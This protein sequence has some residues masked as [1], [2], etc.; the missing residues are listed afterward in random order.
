MYLRAYFFRMAGI[1]AAKAEEM[2]A[3]FLDAAT[4]VAANQQWTYQGRIYTRANLAEIQSS[5]EFWDTQCKRLARGGIRV[6]GVMP[7]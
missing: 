2:L 7:L 5:I 1:T 3:L 4:K 6:R